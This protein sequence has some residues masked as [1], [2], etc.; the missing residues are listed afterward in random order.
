MLTPRSHSTKDVLTLTRRP[1]IA[2]ALLVV[3]GC[4]TGGDKDKEA[5]DDSP[6]KSRPAATASTP[7]PVATPSAPTPVVTP[8]TPAPAPQTP[9]APAVLLSRANDGSAEVALAPGIGLCSTAPNLAGKSANMTVAI[10]AVGSVTN[11]TFDPPD[12]LPKETMRCLDAY[13]RTAH[14]MPAP[15]ATTSVMP[16]KFNAPG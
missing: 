3:G 12:T 15:T 9:V 14:F 1:L 2:L 7:T 4:N 13:M 16:L 11:V 8:S 5:D 10:D 6:R